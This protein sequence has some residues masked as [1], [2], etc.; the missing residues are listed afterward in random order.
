VNIDQF[1]FNFTLHII[2]YESMQP[3]NALLACPHRKSEASLAGGRV[4]L[5]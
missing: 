1:Y 2:P 5:H 4:E 3:D